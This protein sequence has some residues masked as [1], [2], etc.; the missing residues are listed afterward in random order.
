MGEH[1]LAQSFLLRGLLQPFWRLQ[2]G[3]T[4][5]AQGMVIDADNRVLLV[6]HSYR[7]GWCFP[8]GGVE[9]GE[10]VITSLARELEEECGVVLEGTPELV[11]VYSNHRAF[12][13][14]HV[15]LYMV[16][17]YSRPR[18]PAPNRE[19]IAQ[20]YF[21]AWPPPEGCAPATAR[22][23]KEVFEGATKDTYW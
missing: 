23:L 7:P 9:R 19:I 11:G 1:S 22:R 14:D 15:V 20:D 17:T 3:V 18:I 21:T 6:K 12:R 2:R 10:P 5:G 16:K 4:L 8:G 13:N